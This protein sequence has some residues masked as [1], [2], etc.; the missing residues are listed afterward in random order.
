MLTI[1]TNVTSLC[2]ETSAHKKRYPLS[3]T[4]AHLSSGIRINLAADDAAGLQISNRLTAQINGLAIVQRNAND[5][6]SMAQSNITQSL[7]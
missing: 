7:Y 3:V 5:G 6:I 2:F 4:F 1:N